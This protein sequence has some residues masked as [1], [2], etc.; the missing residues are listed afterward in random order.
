M[1]E[2]EKLKRSIAAK[3]KPSHLKGKKS[4][5][6]YSEERRANIAESNRR[7]GI[8]EETKAKIAATLKATNETKRV[9]NLLISIF[10]YSHRQHYLILN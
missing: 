10:A 8:S 4:G 2:S 9:H 7:R 5:Q 1:P 3:G 6:I